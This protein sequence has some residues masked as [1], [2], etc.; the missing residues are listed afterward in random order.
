MEP[1]TIVAISTPQGRGGIGVVRLSGPAAL[2]IA[3]TM[4]RHQAGLEHS[5]ARFAQIVDADGAR[6][7]EAVLT[8]FAMPRSYTGEDVVEIAAHGSPVILEWIVRRAVELGAR[9]A[10]PGEFTERAFL[11]GRMDLTQAEAVRDLIDAQTLEQARVAAEQVGGALAAKIR[12]AKEK[13]VELIATLE[14]GIDFAED[15][16]EVMPHAA[17]LEQLQ[18]VRAPMERLLQSFAYGSVLHTGIKLAIVGRPNAGKSSLFNRL[19]DKERAIVTEIAGTTR[20]VVSERVSLDGIPIEL[21]DTAGLREAED[22]V[23]RIGIE[24]SEQAMADADMVL[25]VVDGT[26]GMSEEDDRIVQAMQGRPFLIVEN[27]MDA[28]PACTTYAVQ[29]RVSA[30]T[31]EGIAALRDTLLTQ[32]RGKAVQARDGVLTNLRQRDAVQRCVDGLMHAEEAVALRVPDEMIL[33]DIY[34]ALRGM[35]ELTGATT[36][37]DVLGLIFSSFCIGK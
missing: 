36:A 15:D 10:H 37:D 6:V 18:A 30:L 1:D 8:Y 20:D 14:A 29:A 3:T 35:D 5:R 16:I 13:L 19:V 31:G 32:I 26:A 7:D 21:M 23:E 25:L 27:K 22:L 33:L 11:R 2:P 34:E 12:P 24:R 4:M 17:M 9:P 28:V